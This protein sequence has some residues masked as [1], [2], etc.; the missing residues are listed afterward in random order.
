MTQ[1]GEPDLLEQEGV[2][3]TLRGEPAGE[4]NP[5]SLSQATSLWRF[6]STLQNTLSRFARAGS[7]HDGTSLRKR[8]ALLAALAAVALVSGAAFSFVSIRDPEATRTT[9]EPKGQAVAVLPAVHEAGFPDFSIDIKD[10]RGRYRFLQ[11][12]VTI[13]FHREVQ[14][15]EDRKAEIRRVI[16]LEARKKGSEWIGQPDSGSRFK[17]EVREKL[18]HVLG[19]GVLKEVYITRYVLL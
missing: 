6:R 2:A 18:R 14:L 4:A 5:E 12:D 1:R 17:R 15:T 13:E 8:N 9:A 3:E 7:P 10:A 11:C 19:E 16:Y